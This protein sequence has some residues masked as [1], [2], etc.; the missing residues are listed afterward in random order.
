[1]QAFATYAPYK[2]E[3]DQQLDSDGLNRSGDGYTATGGLSFGITGKLNGDVYAAYDD[4]SYDDPTLPGIDGW[5]LGAGLQWNPTYLTSVYGR[6]DSSIEET[7]SKYSSGYFRTLYSLRVDHELTRYLQLNAFVSYSNNDYT[8]VPDAP[9]ATRSYDKVWR[10]GIGANWFI[11]RFMYLNA[12][13]D[14]EQVKTDGSDDGYTVNRIWLT[15][16]MEY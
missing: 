12:S 4:R 3:Y 2:I 11:N 6:I 7:T 9:L 5:S 15:L 16:G 13:Y 10:S 8:V 1:M 14:W